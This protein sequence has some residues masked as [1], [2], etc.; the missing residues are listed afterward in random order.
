MRDRVFPPMLLEVW[1]ST[2][3][4]AEVLEFPEGRHYL[5]EDE[6]EAITEALV[7]FLQS[8]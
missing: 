6:P 7:R 5:Q 8:T 1:R 4:H 3:P 2:Y